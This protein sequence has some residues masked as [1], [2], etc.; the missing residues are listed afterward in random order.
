MKPLSVMV[1][2]VAIGLVACNRAQ[3]TSDAAAANGNLAPADE[4][5]AAPPAQDTSSYA[6]SD[7]AD[8]SA[9]AVEAPD[10]PPPLPDYSQPPCPGDDYVWT[11]G[12]WDY[13]SAGYYWVPGAWVMAP[14]VGALW[15]PPWWGFDNGVYLW[16]AGYW[17][18]HIGFYGGIDYGFGYTGRGYY[19]AYWNGGHLFYNR[20]VTNLNTT[21]VHNVY[22][23]RVS[24]GRPGR[25][26]Y[27]GGRGGLDVR[28]TEQESAALRERHM[29]PVAAQTDHAREAAGNRAQ[30][31][32]GRNGRPANVVA[33]RPLATE[34]HAPAERG[35]EPRPA[36]RPAAPASAERARPAERAEP[37]QRPF[38]PEARPQPQERRAEQPAQRPF[39]PEA[40]PAPQERR[41]EQPSQRP[42]QPEA[43][44][45]PQE[46]RANREVRP[47]SP[48]RPAPQQHAVPQHPAPQQHGA[49]PEKKK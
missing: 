29:A 49:P 30:F 8:A 1:V 18:T 36:E 2:A 48:P 39:Q 28:P 38:Q 6:P 15:T 11:P 47:Q 42:F 26:S 35:P 21:I 40:R 13:A 12:Y 31:A 41:A 37:S 19:G 25:V 17:G 24:N 14:Y 32:A 16:H 20:A 23:Y 5:S 4:S 45:Q 3:N 44:P 27:N 46:Q 33:E 10:P 43:R 22:N 7:V 9:Q 34:Y